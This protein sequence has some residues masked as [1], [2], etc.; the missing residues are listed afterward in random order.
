M[1]PNSFL[2]I[3]MKLH[4]GTNLCN[5]DEFNCSD[6]VPPCIPK[7]WVCDGY[8]ECVDGSDEKVEQCG[9]CIYVFSLLYRTFRALEYAALGKWNCIE[10]QFQCRHTDPRC[11]SLTQVCND[12]KDCLDGSDEASQLCGET[13]TFL[14][15]VDKSN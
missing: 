7:N 5:H 12:H 14:A 9:K 8:P 15:Y 2:F 3:I 11:V 10:D 6:E 1:T 13:W 4:S